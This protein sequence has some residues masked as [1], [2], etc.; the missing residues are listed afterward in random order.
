MISFSNSE[1]FAQLDA[2]DR[3]RLEVLTKL[4]QF[5]PG[6]QVLEA[7]RPSEWLSIICTGGLDLRLPGPGGTDITVARLSAGDIYGELEAFAELPAGL[8]HVAREPTLVRAC[9]KDPLK[10]ELR[11]HRPLATGILFAYCRSISEKIRAANDSLSVV[12]ARHPA[13]PPPDGGGRGGHLSTDEM[14]WLSVLGQPGEAAPHT[15]L[16]REGDATRSFY[17]IESGEV[18]VRKAHD[19]A[20]DLLLTR[21]GA[22]SPVG[23]MSFLDGRPRSASVVTGDAPVRYVVVDSHALETSLKVNFTVAFRFLGTMCR[24]LGRT[25]AETAD[26]IAQAGR[27]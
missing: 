17:V 4:D 13:L 11:A 19:G 3:E 18:E 26:Q 21:L 14:S 20:D 10:Q 2:A 22:A 1:R 15:T 5:E 6:E 12:R 7:G 8:R 23:I 9:P 24:I 16:V 27:S 25:F